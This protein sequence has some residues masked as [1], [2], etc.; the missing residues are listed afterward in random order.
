MKNF[1]HLHCHSEYSFFDSTI[2]VVDLCRR[3]KE[4]GMPAV[5]LTDNGNL[6]GALE[7]YETAL[8]IGI[9]PIIGCE[10]YISP[11]LDADNE[12]ASSGKNA[13]RLV[14]LAQNHQGYHNLIR[15][16]T[17]S[18]LEGSSGHHSCVN[19]ELLA[20]HGEG[21][22]A[23]SGG[24]CGEVNYTLLSKGFDSG[25]AVARE[26]AKIFPDRF[27]LEV[28]GYDDITD[29]YI[30]EEILVGVSFMAGLPLV[31]TNDCH[32]LTREDAEAHYFLQCIGDQHTILDTPRLCNKDRYFMSKKE[33]Q[34]ALS[35]YYCPEEAFENAVRIAESCNIELD[36]S[37]GHF[38][39]YALPKGVSPN[40]ELRR[41]ARE[42]LKKRLADF[43][44]EVDES[45]YWERLEHELGSID[46]R[47]SSSDHLFT[48]DLIRWT[49]DNNITV[50]CTSYGSLVD[51]S[52]QI[53]TLDPILNEL[54]F[55]PSGN[56]YVK[57]YVSE[58][59]PIDLEHYLIKKYGRDHVAHELAWFNNMGTKEAVR[60]VGRALCMSTT[61]IKRI[62]KLIPDKQDINSAVEENHELR[63]MYKYHF[64]VD[65]LLNISSKLATLPIQCHVLNHSLFI[66]DRPFDGNV[67]LCKTKEGEFVPQWSFGR[68][69]ASL[70]IGKSCAVSP[71][72]SWSRS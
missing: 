21:L 55:E 67:P 15:L 65:K 29:E 8:R 43:T 12:A 53:T 27:Y 9:K 47:G 17:A 34:M 26:Y 18:H 10:V 2:K 1:V 70:N 41:L 32:Y 28:Q 22:I 7:F 23:L 25:V 66:S 14:L 48:Q 50:F 39:A 40:A 62:T 6:H 11:C 36:L 56:S 59:R 4:L 38:P 24:L 64:L 33:M 13:F 44:P 68:R 37:Y 58:G 54:E 72:S 57:I 71:S 42:G 20:L 60:K 30:G 5:A 61:A 69:I 46:K 52:L 49:T 45:Q 51:W 19:K 31:A 35:D 16:V 3:A 63:N